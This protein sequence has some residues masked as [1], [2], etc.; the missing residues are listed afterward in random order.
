MLWG[1]K[2]IQTLLIL[3]FKAFD[4]SQTKTYFP[5]LEHYA[6]AYG[7]TVL[8]ELWLNGVFEVIDKTFQLY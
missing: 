7:P 4:C 2:K 8:E 1:E 6:T 5:I 3:A